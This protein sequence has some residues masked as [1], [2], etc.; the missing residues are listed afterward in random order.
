MLRSS[1]LQVDDELLREG[2]QILNVALDQED[3]KPHKAKSPVFQVPWV[4]THS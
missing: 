2:P 3:E 1:L 4:G